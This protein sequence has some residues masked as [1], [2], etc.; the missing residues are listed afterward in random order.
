MTWSPTPRGC[1]CGCCKA[2]KLQESSSCWP[3]C[4]ELSTARDAERCHG[5]GRAVPNSQGWRRD[6]METMGCKTAQLLLPTLKT[7]NCL[8]L[9]IFYFIFRRGFD[10]SQSHRVP[11]EHRPPQPACLHLLTA[12][13]KEKR[14]GDRETTSTPACVI[15][16]RSDCAALYSKLLNISSRSGKE[17]SYQ[18]A[19][20]IHVYKYLYR[21]K[22]DACNAISHTVFVSTLAHVP[23][24]HTQVCTAHR[25]QLSAQRCPWAQPGAAD[26]QHS[27][28]SIVLLQC[29][30][31]C[32]L[33][34]K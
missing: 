34:Q 10:P 33:E 1:R 9:W 19:I 21:D 29:T 30:F 13:T 23:V 16:S 8:V 31:L 26:P 32:L 28:L 6:A 14:T 25:E 15:N 4:R 12:D 22:T 17:Q 20:S 3:G 11:P 5:N 24:L 7:T 2:N 27:S 18:T